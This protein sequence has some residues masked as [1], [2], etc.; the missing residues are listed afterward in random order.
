MTWLLTWTRFKELLNPDKIEGGEFTD[1]KLEARLNELP[2]LI[3]KDSLASKRRKTE[4]RPETVQEAEAAK[5]KATA[6]AEEASR[7]A[8]SAASNA[9]PAAAPRSPSR[10]PRQG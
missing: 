4:Q 6:S 2:E 8:A 9:S 1:E 5:A 10:S 7:A 3:V